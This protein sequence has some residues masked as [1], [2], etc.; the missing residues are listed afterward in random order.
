MGLASGSALLEASYTNY[1]GLTA[2]EQASALLCGVLR[3]LHSGV[4]VVIETLN[5]LPILDTEQM[6]PHSVRM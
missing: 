2:G 3:P 6:F 1:K 5:Y 4:R